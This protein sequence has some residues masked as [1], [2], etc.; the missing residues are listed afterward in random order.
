MSPWSLLAASTGAR[1]ADDL[2]VEGWQARRH[3]LMAD[4]EEL[5]AVVEDLRLQLDE[6]RKELRRTQA[7][8]AAL[9][10]RF[11]ELRAIFQ[12]LGAW[13]WSR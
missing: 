9:E 6:L 8:H 7:R 5:G 13:S 11:A 3:F 12:L 4:A 1:G 10:E 2:G